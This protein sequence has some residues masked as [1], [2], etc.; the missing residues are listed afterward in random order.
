MRNFVYIFPV[1]FLI[2]SSLRAQAPAVSTLEKNEQLYRDVMEIRI[3]IFRIDRDKI[4]EMHQPGFSLIQEDLAEAIGILEEKL[5]SLENR[6]H[7]VETQNQLEQAVKLW[8]NLRFHALAKLDKKSFARFFYDTKT[9]DSFLEIM[10]NKM[11]DKFGFKAKKYADMR[12][13]YEA[14]RNLYIMNV[15]YMTDKYPVNKSFEKLFYQSKSKVA[16]YLE[17]MKSRKSFKDEKTAR[18]L[19]KSLNEWKFLRFNMSNGFIPAERT[20]FASVSTMHF[21]LSKLFNE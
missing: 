1:V 20:V 2:M 21:Y 19:A 18:Y 8:D 5:G 4:Y 9:F 15:G 13:N 7:L 17:S 14:I 16:E 10:L 6:L 12:A 11:E 3:Q